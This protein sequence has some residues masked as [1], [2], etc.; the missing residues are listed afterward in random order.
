VRVLLNYVDT[1]GQQA[2]GTK[3]D[4]QAVTVR[5]QLDF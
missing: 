2:G 3:L 4:Q 1:E 5:T